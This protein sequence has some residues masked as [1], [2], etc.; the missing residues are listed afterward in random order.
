MAP[1]VGLPPS[2]PPPLKL[3]G[4]QK[5]TEGH[6]EP[7]V[8]QRAVKENMHQRFAPAVGFE[9]T[10]FFLQYS[11]CYQKGWTISSPPHRW[12]GYIV[13]T[14]LPRHG[15]DLARDCPDENI[16]I[17]SGFPR[18]SPI[19]IRILLLGAANLTGS[20]STIELQGNINERW[21]YTMVFGEYHQSIP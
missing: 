5:A 12:V 4:T 7:T 14:H 11:F 17:P 20:R 19:F 1:P 10:T 8:L 3:R 9:P 15:G 2:L 6:G 16:V 13:S 21:Y 18:I